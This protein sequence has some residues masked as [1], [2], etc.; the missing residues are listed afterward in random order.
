MDPTVRAMKLETLIK[1][2]GLKV[3]CDI[4]VDQ[5]A[6]GL[7]VTVKIWGT[8]P[9]RDVPGEELHA[10]HMLVVEVF[11]DARSILVSNT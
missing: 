2:K 6:A 10:I 9:S 4:R 8:G 11:D 3:G 5:G 7:V 1:G